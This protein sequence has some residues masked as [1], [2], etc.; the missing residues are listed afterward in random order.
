MRRRKSRRPFRQARKHN[1]HRINQDIQISPIRLVEADGITLN[2]IVDTHVA[3]ALAQEKGL[4][5]VEISPNTKPPIAK[6]VDYSKFMYDLRKKRKAEKAKQATVTVKEIRFG[7][8]IGEHDLDF[9]LD[10]AEDFLKSGNK[11]KTYVQFRGR[12]IVHKERGFDV[13]DKVAKRLAK[14]AKIESRPQMF[15]RRLIMMM[16]PLE[17]R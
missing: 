14:I 13:M 9:K 6:V 16:V 5:L 8:N 4:D 2:E 15:G 3:L 7:P 17:S 1:E 12:N 10:K 11:L